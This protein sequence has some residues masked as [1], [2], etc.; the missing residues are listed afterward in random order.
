MIGMKRK[1]RLNPNETKMTIILKLYFT[2]L[3]FKLKKNQKIN[4]AGP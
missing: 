3:V 4:Y 2:P 1:C